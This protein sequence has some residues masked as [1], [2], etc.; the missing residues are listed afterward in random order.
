M[1]LGLDPTKRLPEIGVND[2]VL[3][4]TRQGANK[5]FTAA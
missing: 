4:M 5:R 2:D 3:G 1:I